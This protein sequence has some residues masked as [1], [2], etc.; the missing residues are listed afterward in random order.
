MQ[1]EPDYAALP[2]NVICDRAIVLAQLLWRQGRIKASAQ[3]FGAAVLAHPRV[4][5]RPFKSYINL[6]GTRKKPRGPRELS[7]GRSTA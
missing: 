1:S 2:G 3:M 4:M 6:L 7:P 5:G